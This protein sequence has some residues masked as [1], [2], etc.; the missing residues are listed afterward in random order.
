MT[1]SIASSAAD[2]TLIPRS[3]LFGNP[4]KAMCRISPNGQVL[5]WLA[6]KDGVLN[7]WTAPRD[8]PDQVSCIT[9]DRGRGVR[10][11]AWARNGQ[12]LLYM[13]D[14]NGDENWHIYAVDHGTGD[15]RDLTPINGVNARVVGVS[16]S[17]PGSIAV[18][19]NDRDERW[20]DLYC[21]D[22][23]SADRELLFLNEGEYSGLTLDDH[24][25]LRLTEKSLPDGGRNILKHVDGKFEEMMWIGHEDYLVTG[26]AGFETDGKHFYL[27]SS[28]GRDTAALIRRNWES[29]EEVIIAHH[30]QADIGQIMQHPT[31]RKAEAYSVNHLKLE[32]MP[33]GDA[34]VADLSYLS[35][36][37]PGELSVTG[38]TKDDSTWVVSASSAEDPGAYYLY[39]RSQPS[40]S[41][42]FSSRPDLEAYELKP[43]HPVVIPSRD[44]LELVS[45]LTLPDQPTFTTSETRPQPDAPFPMVLIVHGGPWSRDVYGYNATHQWLANRGYA[46]LSVNF[47]GS[48][49]FGK[50]FVN[51][52]DFEWGRRMHYDLLDAVDWAVSKGI[53]DHSKVAI[54]GGSYGGYATLV[55]LAFTPE[56]FC[57]GIDIVGPSNLETLLATVPPY[58]TSFFENLARRVGD[59][60]TSDGLALLKERSPLNN[61]DNIARPLLIGQGANDP[62]VKQAESDQIV[63]AMNAKDLPVTYVLYPDEGHGFAR[64]EN[65]LSFN[66]IVEAFL[67]AHLHGALE[68][69][70]ADFQGASLT[71]PNGAGDV[72][73]LAGALSM[74]NA[75]NS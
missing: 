53:A 41:R 17:R 15:E 25:A 54:M 50:T 31:T 13:Q 19:L 67:A 10:M 64:P 40:L 14:K 38:R 4:A 16:W 3:R 27:L 49:G 37:L 18:G 52:G 71:V 34:V 46:A 51:A 74:Q 70:G 24:Y 30:N 48:T 6:P 56:V 12:H 32:W 22:L 72:P 57:C 23:E 5:S 29:D 59:P 7:L 8:A 1:Q 21:V 39:E 65:R 44:G 66:A 47:R 9:N 61:A 68:P 43:L 26:V 55:G 62:R 28:I 73:G 69:I 42:L 75:Q 58:W 2:Q 45:Y 33:I 63:K 20:H 35:N 11:Y 60:R 36:N